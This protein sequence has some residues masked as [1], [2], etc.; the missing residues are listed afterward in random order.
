MSPKSRKGYYVDGE[1]V[2]AGGG[3]SVGGDAQDTGRPSRTARKNASADLQKTGEGLLTLRAE[4][5]EELDL[6]ERLRDAI[7]EAKRLSN[8]G[9]KRRQLQFIGK[10]MRKLEPEVLEAVDAALRAARHGSPGPRSFAA[11]RSL[12][13]RRGPRD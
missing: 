11:A 4:R 6:P 13:G 3:E 7:A 1:F 8:F 10:L 12:P 2:P 5:L 9:A